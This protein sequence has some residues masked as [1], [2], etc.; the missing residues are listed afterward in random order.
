MRAAEALGKI[1]SDAAIPELVKA[2]NHED[3][4]VC[5]RAAKALGKIGSD[6]AIPELVQALNH[7]DSYVR[8]SAAEALGKIGSDAAIPELVKALNHE[9][10]YVRWRAAYA[11]SKIGS[12]AA[13]PELVK[14]LNHEN[15][16]VR[17]RAADTLGEL[18]SD[19]AIP[20]LVKALNDEDSDVRE[21]AAYALGY[22]GS[23]AAIPE[24]VKALNDEDSDVRERA[25]YALGYIGSDAA[26]SELVQA[27]NHEDYSVRRRA[28]DAL[29]KIASPELLPD[30]SERLKTDE[31]AILINT[32]TAIQE[33]CK[34]YN[35]TLT[36]P[37]LPPTQPPSHPMFIL[38]LSDLHFGT[39]T[40]ATRWHSQLSDDLH[41]LLSQLQPNQPPQLDALIISGDIANTSTPDEYAAAALFLSRLLPDF[42]LR[43]NQLLIVPGNHDLNWQH[44]DDAYQ[45]VKRKDYPGSLNDSDILENN[46]ILD[47]NY[48]LVPDSTQYQQR[49]QPFSHF[50]EQILG[51]PY[52]LQPKQQY[53]LQHFPAQNLLLLG[54][55]SA[56]KL[57]HHP[58]Y[59]TRASINPDALTNALNE[60][61]DTP[62]YKHSRLKIAV[63]HHP[64]TSPYEDRIK[65]HDFMQRLAQNGFRLALHGHIHQAGTSDYQYRTGSQIDIIAAGTF[66]APVREWVPGYPLQYNLLKWQDNQLTVYTRK[67]SQLNGAWQPD[68]MWVDSDGMSARAYYD[69]ALAPE[70]AKPTT[71]PKKNPTNPNSTPPEAIE[72]FFSYAHQDEDLR[73]E[74]AKHLKL[75]ERQGI[76]SGWHDRKISA[77]QE[78]AGEIDRHLN[79]ARIILLL[80]SADFIASDYCYDIEL[81]R[82]I[83]RHDAGEA[84]VIPIILR[85]VDWQNVPFDKLRATPFGKLQPLPMEGKPVT[86]W[87]D[88]DEAML[89]IVQ[90]IRAAVGELG[91]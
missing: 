22:I 12:N 47:G 11:L 40:D 37:E 5:W 91:R 26:I 18:G 49:F 55:N 46:L 86:K 72:V 19:A 78:R 17:R 79:A 88:R 8:E 51:K 31:E 73:D 24:L 32:I 80:I 82:A 53:Q 35:Y 83:A 20:G 15:F 61:N 84:R 89:D 45:P 34:F 33:R 87:R 75:L 7:E 16:Y 56:W 1:G 2:L 66:G 38:H 71:A 52:P 57:N 29:G 77:G 85:P 64:L 21:R 59:K 14:A 81:Q 74:L 48:I 67:R 13:I 4:S 36:Q 9:D 44:S 50:H 43:R 62:T 90:G 54:L 65:T 76:I 27:L 69:I 30:L 42:G 23:D 58:T 68:A 63:W 60:I 25:A 28:A 10:S 39:P 3:S 41:Q 6:A 70:A